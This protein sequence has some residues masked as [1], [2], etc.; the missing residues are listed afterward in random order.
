MR[1]RCRFSVLGSRHRPG[2]CRRLVDGDAPFAFSGPHRL[3]D[4]RR[5]HRPPPRAA[6]P[7]AV[8][9]PP[10]RPHARARE[11]RSRSLA[12]QVQVGATPDGAQGENLR[13]APPV[14]AGEQ[15][16]LREGRC[17]STAMS[18]TESRQCR[19]A[20]GHSAPHRGQPASNSCLRR[21]RLGERASERMEHVVRDCRGVRRHAVTSRPAASAAAQAP[22]R[23]EAARCGRRAESARSGRRGLE[24]V[25][26]QQPQRRGGPRAL[27]QAAR[28]EG[29]LDPSA[30]RQAAGTRVEVEPNVASRTRKRR[31]SRAPTGNASMS[32]ARRPG[33]AAPSMSS[34]RS[35]GPAA[36][37]ASQT[38]TI[39]VGRAAA[40]A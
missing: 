20:T 34:A 36:R 5:R 10:G 17:A 9:E 7:S 29:E 13:F 19:R 4:S 22:P 40:W 35:I 33:P 16:H 21:V 8:S 31:A 27:K 25:G 28:V 12:Q 32:P 23:D 3:G 6:P 24:T 11:R 37:P 15:V 14:G 2:W 39:A 30:A 38:R 26:L 1:G 18:S